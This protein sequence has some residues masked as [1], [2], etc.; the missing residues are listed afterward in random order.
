MDFGN[1]TQF[2]PTYLMIVVAA[3]VVLGFA[4]KKSNV[5]NDKY[6][7]FLLLIFG[8]TFAVLIDIINQEYKTTYE[9]FVYGILHGIICWGISVAGHQTFKQLQKEE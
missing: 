3:I 6:I 5:I 8:I 4:F 1:L 2:L 7:T 9:A